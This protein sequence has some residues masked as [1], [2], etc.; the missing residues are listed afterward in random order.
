VAQRAAAAAGELLLERFGGP[1]RGVE[2][3]SSRTDLVSDADRD[4][5]AAIEE[6]LSAE[7]PDDGLLAEE[8][9][10]REAVSGRR[11]V[12]D[13]LDGTT[14]FLYGIPAW[15]V[16]IALE[17][18][19]G[20]A[21]GVVADPVRGETFTAIRGRG[22]ACN[23]EPIEVTGEERLDTALVATGFSY[24]AQER[25]AQAALLAEV[26]PRVRDIRRVGAAALDLCWVATGRLD[27]YYERGLKHWD[28]A[29][30][31]LLV[32]EAGGRLRWLE[33]E[34]RGLVAGSPMVVDGLLELV[35]P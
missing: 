1:A 22:A 21:L 13:P 3:K 12:V 2:R 33:G 26:L 20:S 19:D 32:A 35:G 18:A 9:S 25:Q 28:W 11:W 23:G 14:N 17:D 16:S 34:P 4:A 24:E 29:A 8:G 27:G 15:A 30:A 10:S 7:R 6:I 31:S 5:E